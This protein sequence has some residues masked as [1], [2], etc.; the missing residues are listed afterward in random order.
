MLADSYCWNDDGVGKLAASRAAR[1]SGCA[2]N[3][4]TCSGDAQT[5]TIIS[6]VSVSVVTLTMPPNV[7]GDQ[8]DSPAPGR[9][10]VIQDLANSF[11]VRRGRDDLATAGD[12]AR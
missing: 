10:A 3:A 11:D 6:P 5:L 1:I 2:V 12:A 7:G 8:E 9:L 4:G